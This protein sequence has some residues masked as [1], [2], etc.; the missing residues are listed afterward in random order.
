ML[1]PRNEPSDADVHDVG[2]DQMQQ[3]IRLSIPSQ[4]NKHHKTSPR[5][6][7]TSKMGT[8]PLRVERI[9]NSLLLREAET[10]GVVAHGREETKL[11]LIRLIGL[12]RIPTG[13]AEAHPRARKVNQTGTRNV[14]PGVASSRPD[15]EIAD[16]RDV[17]L[18]VGGSKRPIVRSVVQCA[19]ARIRSIA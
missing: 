11:S 15:H 6:A 8:D 14:L 4:Q 10:G 12:N 19:T 7:R 3:S 9:N 16:N 2:Q 1:S 17:G 18:Q 13:K 5:N